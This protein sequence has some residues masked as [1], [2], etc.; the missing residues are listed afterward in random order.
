MKQ[1]SAV[2]ARNLRARNSIALA[3]FG[4]TAFATLCLC[5]AMTASAQTVFPVEAPTPKIGQIATFSTVDLWNNKELSVSANELVAFDGD[6]MV[7]RTK[8]AGR[9]GVATGRA[10]KSWNICRSMRGSEKL[11]C[12]GSLKFPMQVGFKHNI[13]ERPW[14]DGMGYDNAACEVQA[15][16][17]VT[18]PSGSY[19]ALRIVCSGFWT[20][21]FEG[22]WSGRFNETTWYAPSI[23]RAV[24]FQLNI[25]DSRGQLDT[26]TQTELV[27]FVAGN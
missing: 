15:E 19:D 25:F 21:V 9:D 4:N 20:R 8:T 1:N 17:K 5:L 16:E 7:I 26:K 13:K 3:C 27:E 2:N 14:R 11:V 12:E 10:D 18:I 24:K 23:S 6:N 22:S